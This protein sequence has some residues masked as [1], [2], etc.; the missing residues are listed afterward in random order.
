MT[1]VDRVVACRNRAPWPLVGALSAALLAIG[2]GGPV[3]TLI[4]Y[5]A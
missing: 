3:T 5:S 1:S 4:I 2:A